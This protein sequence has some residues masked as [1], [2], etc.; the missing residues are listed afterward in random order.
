MSREALLSNEEKLH[1]AEKLLQLAEL[2]RKFETEREKV[3]CIPLPPTL[4][5]IRALTCAYNFSYNVWW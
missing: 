1:R 3:G 5:I 2:S 4:I